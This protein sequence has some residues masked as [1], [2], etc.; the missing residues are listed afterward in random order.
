MGRRYEQLSLEQ[1][2]TIARHRQAGKTIR[3]IAAAMDRAPSTIARELKRNSGTQV[4]YQPAYAEQQTKSRRWKGSR[5]VRDCSLQSLVLKGLGQGWSPAQVSGRLKKEKGRNVISYESI[6]R[7]IDSQ[8]RRTKDYRWRLYLPRGKSKRGWR[9]R[10]G[11]SPVQ[12]IE[13]RVAIDRRPA[14]IG[15]RRQAGHWEGDLML[16]AK[17]G[18]AVLVAH[19]RRSRLLVVSRQP[20]K[21]AAPVATK[22]TELFRSLPKSLRRTITFD[23]GTEFSYHHRLHK[24]SMRT[25]FCDPHAPWQKGGIENGIGRMRRGLPRKTDLATLSDQRLLSLVRCYNHTPRKCLNYKTPAEVFTRDLLHFK[26]ESTCPLPR[27]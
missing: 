20:N 24:L 23:N 3:K 21:A 15:K 16:F 18:Q 6:Y 12:H 7:F 10:R 8:I 14:Y 17:Y 1:R 22:L 19:E 2:C 26:C 5:L 27:A 25:F 9:G 13:G 4:G 11:G